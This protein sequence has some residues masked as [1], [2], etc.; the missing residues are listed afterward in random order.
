LRQHRAEGVFQELR[1]VVRRGN[2]AD[3][4][5]HG[6]SPSLRVRSKMT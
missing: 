1:L 3:Q 5:R 6:A 2:D 4:R